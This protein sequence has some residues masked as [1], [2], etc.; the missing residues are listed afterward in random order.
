MTEAQNTA[1]GILLHSFNT[2]ELT[3]LLS[4]ICDKLQINIAIIIKEGSPILK[5]LDNT[6]VFVCEIDS[7]VGIND[8]VKVIANMPLIE[9]SVC[10]DKSITVINKVKVNENDKFIVTDVGYKFKAY[11]T[12]QKDISVLDVVEITNIKTNE[13]YF[14]FKNNLI[15]C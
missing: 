12:T 15:L 5:S 2:E 3:G 14:S 1:I 6:G 13:K 9:Y 11:M 10:K 7:E 8:F 4:I